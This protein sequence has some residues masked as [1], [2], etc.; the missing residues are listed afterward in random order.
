MV[1]ARRIA[2]A[3]LMILIVGGMAHAAPQAPAQPRGAAAQAQAQPAPA[4]VP[5]EERNAEET[6]DQLMTL[7]EKYPPALG[8]VLKLDPSLLAN[9]AYLVP[10][11]ALASFL[12]AHPEV[13]HNPGYFLARVQTP[14]GSWRPP[15][16]RTAT[17]EMWRNMFEDIGA[18]TVFVV[19]TLSLMWLIRTLLDWRRWTRLARSQAD[20]HAK[21]LDRFTANED[22][23]TYI[24]TPAGKRFLESGPVLAESGPRP[25]GAPVSRILWSFQA[26]I[27]L[28]VGGLGLVYVS[29]RVIPEV[30]QGLSVLGVLAIALGLGFI[31]SGVAAWVISRRMGLFEPVM[32]A[33]RDVHTL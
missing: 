17:I 4:P 13:A 27:V 24:Q 14:E 2:A 22:L 8:R 5:F 33:G 21:L 11:P 7:L 12:A 15:D 28:A 31:L 23:L 16:A 25:L 9:Q 10:Y 29:G 26:G 20:V 1:L 6:R 19:V 32:G 3:A 18:F 30:G